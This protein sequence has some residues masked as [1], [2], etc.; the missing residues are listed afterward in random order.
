MTET[1]TINLTPEHKAIVAKLRY[2]AR[3]Y[4]NGSYARGGSPSGK[5]YLDEAADAIE[6]LA[7][8]A[9][10]P[11]GEVK[12]V[13]TFQGRRLTP[14]G[15][16]EFWGSLL[17]DQSSDPPI[18]ALLYTSP[19]PS[20]SPCQFS[21]DNGGNLYRRYREPVCAACVPAKKE[22]DKWES[23]RVAD[24]NAGWN[25]CRSAML[26][27]PPAPI[28]GWRMVPVE[29]TAEMITAGERSEGRSTVSHMESPRLIY[30]AM[31]AAAPQPGDKA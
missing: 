13:A 3:Q 5:H 30:R 25:A 31:L 14:E 22:T 10:A 16:S 9:A 27:T 11:V 2:M 21:I 19:P 6:E 20:E 7:Q 28:E 26:T 4:T 15:T 1:Q 23:A 24:F 8:T 29:P 18:G 12:P 17:C